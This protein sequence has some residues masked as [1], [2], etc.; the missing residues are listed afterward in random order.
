[1]KK[2]TDSLDETV[3]WAGTRALGAPNKWGPDLGRAWEKMTGGV[4]VR[5]GANTENLNTI[6]A[7]ENTPG[8]TVKN[9]P[10]TGGPKKGSREISDQTVV[11]TIKRVQDLQ[12]GESLSYGGPQTAP[13]RE[14]CVNSGGL[15]VLRQV[16][17]GN[18]HRTT[19]TGAQ[20]VPI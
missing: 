18:G 1:M 20:T 17:K 5:P 8:K 12:E 15:A 19:S 2:R 9:L 14:V 3:P 4:S 13:S 7:P 10:E 6:K 16:R 11:D